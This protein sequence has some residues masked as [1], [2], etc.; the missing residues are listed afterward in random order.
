MIGGEA[1]SGLNEAALGRFRNQYIGFVYQFHHLLAE[2]T[3][4]ENAALPLIIRG[5][6]KKV[7]EQRFM[8]I[9]ERVGMKRVPTISRVSYRAVSASEWRLPG[10]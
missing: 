1:L 3:A 7:A 4:V 8:Q 2:F 10:R 6:S 9:L 5:Q